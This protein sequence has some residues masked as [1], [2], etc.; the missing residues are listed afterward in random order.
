MCASPALKTHVALLG[1]VEKELETW[2]SK[3][4]AVPLAIEYNMW[5]ST[6]ILYI[7]EV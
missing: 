3:L 5:I 1:P 7:Y 4:S 6:I 2:C